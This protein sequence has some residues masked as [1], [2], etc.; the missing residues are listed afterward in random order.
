MLT[1]AWFKIGILSTCKY[2]ELGLMYIFF[3]NYI[4]DEVERII[5]QP[6]YW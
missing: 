2:H 1:D 4:L 6:I 3:L 5:F